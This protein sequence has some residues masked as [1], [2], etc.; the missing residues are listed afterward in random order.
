MR[1]STMTVCLRLAESLA[2]IVRAMKSCCT[3]A[4]RSTMILIWRWGYDPAVARN[5]ASAPHPAPAMAVSMDR[6]VIM[7]APIARAPVLDARNGILAAP[8]LAEKCYY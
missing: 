4:G 1:F 6:R 3:P 2:A 8:A 5:D 7:L